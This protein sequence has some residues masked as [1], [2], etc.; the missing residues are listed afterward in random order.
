MEWVAKL[1]KEA[2]MLRA[3][4]LRIK[5]L[6]L[7]EHQTDLARRCEELAKSMQKELTHQGRRLRRVYTP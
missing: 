3:L 6:P 2:S 7:R 5:M 4:A 1:Y